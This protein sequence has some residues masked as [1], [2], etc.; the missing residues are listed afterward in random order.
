[1]IGRQLK[2]LV[3]AG[4]LTAII[5]SMPAGAAVQTVGVTISGRADQAAA[6]AAVIERIAVEP[7]AVRAIVGAQVAATP[8]YREAIATSVS[9][10]YPGFASVIAEAA[11]YTRPPPPPE[12]LSSFAP[13]VVAAPPPAVIPK[14]SAPRLHINQTDDRH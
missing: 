1:M 10:A 4:L 8:D 13:V 3:S 11:G 7:G 12:P 6:I 5:A 2:R 14:P 9:A